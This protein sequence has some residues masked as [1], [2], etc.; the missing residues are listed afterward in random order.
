M[1]AWP[2]DQRLLL[3]SDCLVLLLVV[4][5]GCGSHADAAPLAEPSAPDSA[6]IAPRGVCPS[7]GICALM[8][9]GDSIT[10]GAGIPNGDGGFTSGYRPPLWH[11]AKQAEL[12]ITFVGS[13]QSGPDLV[14]GTPWP[15]AH[16]GHSGWTIDAVGSIMTG[17][18]VIA[19]DRVSTYHPDVV[20]LMVGTNDVQSNVDLPNAPARLSILLDTIVEARTDVAIVV[21]T[22]PP[23]TDDTQNMNV[24]AFNAALPGVVA[25]QQSLLHHVALVDGHAMFSADAG[26]KT[27]YLADKLH[28]T[29]AGYAVIA[30]AWLGALTR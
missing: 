18:Q 22:I 17:L 23:T 2:I 21:S 13:L 10:D 1:R 20:L 29:D 16:E 27:D 14:D 7:V 4:A 25:R 11:A 15:R 28:P 8:P 3:F 24:D 5:I 19:K 6:S 9:F 12:P 30:E 26:Y